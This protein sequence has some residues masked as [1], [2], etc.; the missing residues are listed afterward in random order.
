[1]LLDVNVIIYSGYPFNVY[2]QRQIICCFT[3]FS[4]QT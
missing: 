2:K 1:M 3:Y 4:N